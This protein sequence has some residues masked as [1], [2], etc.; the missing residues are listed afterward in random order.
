M[1]II[2]VSLTSGGWRK[3]TEEE[4]EED[5]SGESKGSDGEK[6]SMNEKMQAMQEIVLQIQ[7][8]FLTCSK[9]LTSKFKLKLFCRYI[10]A[11]LHMYLKALK[12]SST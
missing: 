11:S 7:V 9:Y 5:K 4:E 6:K 8:Q 1:P 2:N 12:M 3:E 10:L